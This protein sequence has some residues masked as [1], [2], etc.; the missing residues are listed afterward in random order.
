MFKVS[1][2]EALASSH[3]QQAWDS[4]KGEIEYMIKYKVPKP[5]EFDLIPREDLGNIIRA[6]MF[7]KHKYFADGTFDKMKARLVAGGHKQTE[8]TYDQTTSPAKLL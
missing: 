5:I 3:N 1:I 2:K 6:F 8:D 7:L 4:I